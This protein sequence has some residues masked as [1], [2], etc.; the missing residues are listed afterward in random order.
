MQAEPD[1]NGMARWA[2]TGRTVFDNKGNPV[3]KYEPYF[4]PDPGYDTEASLVQTGYC[5]ILRY[6]PLGRVVR[7][8]DPDGTFV[9]TEWDA[10]SEVR[11]DADDTVLD[12]AWYADAS[13]RPGTDPLNRAARLAASNANT[14]STRAVDP[15]GR[16]FLTVANNGS[17]GQYRTHATLDIQGNTLAVTDPRGNVVLQQIFDAQGNVLRHQSTDAGT[18]CALGDAVGHPYRVWDPRGYLGRK[19]YDSLRRMT[20]L[21]VTPPGGPEFLAEQIVY[22]E[23]LATPNFRGHLY[24]HYDGAGVQTNAAYD[25]EGRITHATR[26]LASNYQTTPSWTALAAITDPTAFLAA[27]ASFLETDVFDTWTAYDAMSRVVSVTSPDQSRLA[28]AYNAAS[29]LGTVTAFMQGSV[30]ASP[31]IT[32]IDYNAR[33]QRTNVSC[34]QGVLIQN[35]YDDRTKM[36]LRVQTTRQSDGA[37]LQDLNYTYDPARNIVQITDQAQQTVYFAGSVTSGT[38]LFEYDAIYQL[39]SATGRE[40]PGQVGYTL[41]GKRLSRSA[42]HDHPAPERSSGAPAV[43]GNLRLR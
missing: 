24:Q 3:K 18:T 26:Q 20:Q 22:G 36:V 8:D 21:W 33:G 40:Q 27:A 19:V 13:S 4:A 15:L 7:I 6:D 37:A 25:F 17:A 41:G 5:Q 14:P 31:V 32:N 29:L 9:T 2:G 34:G 1:A 35:T 12:S 28:L 11:S 23:G 30:T 10:W 39:T 38:Q 43:H 42:V 16:T